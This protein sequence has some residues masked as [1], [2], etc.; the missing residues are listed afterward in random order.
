MTREAT[1]EA[2]M[3]FKLKHLLLCH[4]R[5]HLHLHGDDLLGNETATPS[6]HSKSYI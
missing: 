5:K 4:T 6:N 2:T 3:Y 1:C